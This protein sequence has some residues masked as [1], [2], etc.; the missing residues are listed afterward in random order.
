MRSSLV[1]KLN[2]LPAQKTQP[3]PGGQSELMTSWKK[4]LHYL[5]LLFT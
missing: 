5:L 4:D 2:E 1:L 3:Q